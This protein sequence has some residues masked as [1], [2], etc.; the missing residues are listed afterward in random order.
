MGK[1]TFKSFV[2]F[3]LKIKRNLNFVHVRTLDVVVVVKKVK[4]P[5]KDNMMLML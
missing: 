1:D 2:A 3:L 5:S 4:F